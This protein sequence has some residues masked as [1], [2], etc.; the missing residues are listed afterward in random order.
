VV[1]LHPV[2]KNKKDDMEAFKEAW[3][4]YCV[5]HN[6]I[7]V[8]PKAEGENGWVA[9]ESDFVQQTTREIMGQYTIDRQR[10]IAHG[11]GVG[12]Q[13][14]YYLGF[15]Q[16]DLFRGV[17]TTGAVLASQV[18]DNVAN[19]PLSFYM[20]AGGKDPL[21][22]EITTSKTKIAE[23][24]FSVVFREI[25]MMGHQYLDS[26]TLAELVRWIDSLDRQ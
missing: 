9:S 14:A 12:G 7:V 19:Q 4:D 16:R 3:E 22:E 21:A 13:M 18:K 1:W 24:K 6:I 23:K 2:G 5:D 20:I 11:M 8:M 17:A 10:I 15:N 25:P 26:K